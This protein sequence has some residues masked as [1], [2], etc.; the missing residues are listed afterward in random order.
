MELAP[1]D[2]VGYP[3]MRV[4][5]CHAQRLPRLGRGYAVGV[6]DEDPSLMQ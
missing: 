2:R 6:L 4:Q 5:D 3:G 1:R